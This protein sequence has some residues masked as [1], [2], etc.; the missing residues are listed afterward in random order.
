MNKVYGNIF[1]DIAMILVRREDLVILEFE[2]KINWGS[3][4]FIGNDDEVKIADLKAIEDISNSYSSNTFNWDDIDFSVSID[5]SAY[6]AIL[7]ESYDINGRFYMT[8]NGCT[9]K[10]VSPIEIITLPISVTVNDELDIHTVR[11]YLHRYLTDLFLVCN[12]AAPGIIDF[13]NAKLDGDDEFHPIKLSNFHFNNTLENLSNKRVPYVVYSDI[14]QVKTWFDSL[15]IGMKM[16]ANSSIEKAM[17]S[18][19]HIIHV[20]RNDIGIIPWI[21]H[22]LEAIYGTN[23]GRGFNDL[24]ERVN[25]L[26]SI[27]ERQKKGLKN[28]LR[29]LNDLRGKFIHGGFNV[30]HPM[31]LHYET[32]ENVDDLANFGISLV[33]SSIQYLMLNNWNGIGVIEKIFGHKITHS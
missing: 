22:A 33:I 16:E 19:L 4:G 7:I 10:Q 8:V 29:A 18:L 26:L 1:K 14:E 30:S 5:W 25:F 31:N 32:N 6:K 9:S 28:K 17:F 3:R 13:Y 2:L 20:D 23:A 24:S 27:K 21:F 12:L 15:N 11:R